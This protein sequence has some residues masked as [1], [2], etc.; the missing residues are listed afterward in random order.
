MNQ[1]VQEAEVITDI[2]EGAAKVEHVKNNT[3]VLRERLFR[4]VDAVLVDSKQREAVKQLID[5]EVTIWEKA[6]KQPFMTLG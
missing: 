6:N 4:L 1:E 2:A 5:E 3:E